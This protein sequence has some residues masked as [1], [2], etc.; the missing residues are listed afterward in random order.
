MPDDFLNAMEGT[1]TNETLFHCY[2]R[3][4]MKNIYKKALIALAGA[5]PGFRMP[6]LSLAII[7][8]CPNPYYYIG[9]IS[10]F[11]ILH[12]LLYFYLYILSF[13]L[14]VLPTP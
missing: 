2:L 10:D 12:T 1:K 4:I 6:Q 13:L 7:D 3:R 5:T 14:M 11:S 9:F 8:A